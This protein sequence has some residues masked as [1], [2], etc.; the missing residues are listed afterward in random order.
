MYGT[1][2]IYR[3]HLP[4]FASVSEPLRELLSNDAIAW[5]EEHTALTKSI[6]EQLLASPPMMNFTPNE[7]T[8]L[9]V[10][11]GK[12]GL[13]GILLQRDP[14]KR[15]RWLQVGSYSRVWTPMEPTYS[16]TE[17]ELIAI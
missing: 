9:V 2:S 8:R 12:L 16:K 6:A 17:L 13:A 3:E 15:T 10:H 7:M 4:D 5:T 1:L 14:K 11:I